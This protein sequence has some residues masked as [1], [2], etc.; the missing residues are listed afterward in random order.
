MQLG[1][2]QGQL[3]PAVADSS[4]LLEGTVGLFT[5]RLP[6]KPEKKRRERRGG[7]GCWI[8]GEGLRIWGDR[9]YQDQL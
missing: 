7:V 1:G 9:T 4:T 3:A 2:I 8:I 5:R 6:L